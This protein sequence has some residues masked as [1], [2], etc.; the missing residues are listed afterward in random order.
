LKFMCLV[1]IKLYN[2]LRLNLCV[3]S[4]VIPLDYAK[5]AFL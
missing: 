5:S 2:V 1:Y 3:K 4:G